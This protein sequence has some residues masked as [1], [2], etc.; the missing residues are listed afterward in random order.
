MKDSESVKDFFDQLLKVV[1]Y[2]IL[3]G[4]EIKDQRIVEKVIVSFLEKFE[5]KISNL[6]KFSQRN[7]STWIYQW[8]PCN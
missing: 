5:A 1:S 7:L 2:V 8:F 3:L 4:R 6:E